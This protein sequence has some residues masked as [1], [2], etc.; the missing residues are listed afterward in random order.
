LKNGKCF[1]PAFQKSSA[2]MQE[3]RR[4]KGRWELRLLFEKLL[5]NLK[6]SGFQRIKTY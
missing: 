5:A 4:S 6:A 2:P 3:M 1:L